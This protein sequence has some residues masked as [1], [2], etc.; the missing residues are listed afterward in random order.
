MPGRCFRLPARLKGLSLSTTRCRMTAQRPL[1]RARAEMY[2]RPTAPPSTPSHPTHFT[3]SPQIYHPKSNHPTKTPLR[4]HPLPHL[5]PPERRPHPPTTRRT[6]HH[7]H[8]HLLLHPR[9]KRG[10]LAYHDIPL[11]HLEVLAREGE[12]VSSRGVGRDG[13][14]RPRRAEGQ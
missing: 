4:P 11:E 6:P 10:H 1:D 7:T 2:P 12:G 8:E 13:L 3:R 5:E 14:D 9:P